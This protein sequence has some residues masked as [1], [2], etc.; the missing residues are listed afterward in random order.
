MKAS[1]CSFAK[2]QLEYLG[3]I[4]SSKGVATDPSKTVD[5]LNW[6]PPASVT[7]LRGF[8]GLDTIENL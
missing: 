7:E 6:P 2:D 5:M 3:H 1:R 4:I 8:L